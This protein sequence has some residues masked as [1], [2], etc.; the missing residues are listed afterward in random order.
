M[1]S[2]LSSFHILWNRWRKGFLPTLTQRK[3][4]LLKEKNFKKGDLVILQ[5]KNVPRSH[6]SLG[7]VTKIHPGRVGVIRIVK[8][9]TPTNKIVRPANKLYLMEE[10]NN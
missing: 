4:G 7:R 3:E 9:R 1:E 6:W 10:S 8:L 5:V 2:S